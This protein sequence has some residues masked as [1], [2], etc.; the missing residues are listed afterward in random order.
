MDAKDWIETLGLREHPEGGYFRE[1]YRAGERISASALPPRFDGERCFSTAIYYL[2]SSGSVST[3]HRIRQDEIW[4]FYDG[5]PVNIYIID[6]RRMTVLRLG[7]DPAKG[8]L[9]MVA[10]P[11]G[12]IFGAELKN[13]KS[14]ALLGCTVSPGFEFDDFELIPRADL[15]QQFPEH[16]DIVHRLAR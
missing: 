6:K 16:F 7:R 12:A 1:V 14:H 3:F 9:P 5:S 11:Q 13:P 10:I 8:Q 2:L 4:H 15:L